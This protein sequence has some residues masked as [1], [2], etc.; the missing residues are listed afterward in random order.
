MKDLL[1]DVKD[2][3]STL[4]SDEGYG[5]LIVKLIVQVCSRAFGYLFCAI[6]V[7][8]LFSTIPRQTSIYPLYAQLASTV[9]F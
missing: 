1:K 6:C 7:W 9:Y 3:L 8:H 4:S 2:Q 5:D